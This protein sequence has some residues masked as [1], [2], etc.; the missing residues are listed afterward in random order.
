MSILNWVRRGAFVNRTPNSQTMPD[1][2]ESTQEGQITDVC[3]TEV[4]KAI[5]LRRRKAVNTKHTLLRLQLSW[6]V[7]RLRMVLQKLSVI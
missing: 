2:T 5:T 3:N 6:P 4:G 1:P 7:M